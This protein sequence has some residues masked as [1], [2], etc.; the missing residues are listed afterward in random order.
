[1]GVVGIDHR[2]GQEEEGGAG[3]HNT[4]DRQLLERGR[5]DPVSCACE[6]P[7]L[8]CVVDGNVADGS[9]VFAAVDE[10]EIIC[11]R[12]A[13]LQIRSENGRLQA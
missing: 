2:V 13:L 3:V 4:I 9:G 6:F 12:G 7:E 8:L 1:L 5:P 10:S 11:S